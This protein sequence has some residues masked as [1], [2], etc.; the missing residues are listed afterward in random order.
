MFAETLIYL[1]AP[2][3]AVDVLCDHLLPFILATTP[4]VMG[5]V[6][7]MMTMTMTIMMMAISMMLMIIMMIVRMMIIMIIV[8]MMIIMMTMMMTMMMMMLATTMMTMMI[9]SNIPQAVP[10]TA[11]N[12][13]VPAMIQVPPTP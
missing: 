11:C 9:I 12:D 3:Q 4:Q 10:T 8:R 13:Y 1:A 7:M 6:M 2:F 5:D